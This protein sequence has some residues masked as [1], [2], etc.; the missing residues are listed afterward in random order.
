LSAKLDLHIAHEIWELTGG[1]RCLVTLQRDAH[2]FASAKP[3]ASI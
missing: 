2:R 1:D 3:A